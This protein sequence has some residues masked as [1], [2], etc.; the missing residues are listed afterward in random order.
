MAQRNTNHDDVVAV[1]QV[2]DVHVQIVH[3]T[4]E[5][6]D[7]FYWRHFRN[8]E[9]IGQSTSV[10]NTIQ[11]AIEASLAV[12]LPDTEMVG[13]GDVD[14]VMFDELNIMLAMNTGNGPITSIGEASE[15]RGVLA[16]GIQKL[17]AL[18]NAVQSDLDDIEDMLAS[19]NHGS[20]KGIDALHRIKTVFQKDV[21]FLQELS[22]RDIGILEA[23]IMAMTRPE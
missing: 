20:I 2:D 6:V 21:E 13:V 9:Q 22:A 23:F 12:L 7:G 1:G 3:M 11:A 10:W 15:W 16:G 19:I 14:Q 17:D 18:L 4:F 5:G 8:D